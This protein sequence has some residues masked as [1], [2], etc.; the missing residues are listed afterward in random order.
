LVFGMAPALEEGSG[1]LPDD[2]DELVL[3]PDPLVGSGRKLELAVEV[4]A[5]TGCRGADASGTWFKSGSESGRFFSASNRSELALLLDPLVGCFD[6]KLPFSLWDFGNVGGGAGFDANC[7]VG[8]PVVDVGELG[9]DGVDLPEDD[10]SL[11][12]GG[13]CRTTSSRLGLLI[14]G[15]DAGGGGL[16]RSRRSLTLL[17][18]LPL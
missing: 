6:W 16:S 3:R 15:L 17:R 13:R 4:V 2:K 5:E 11:V 7:F 1:L 9:D 14:F 18:L 12:T 8:P 10:G